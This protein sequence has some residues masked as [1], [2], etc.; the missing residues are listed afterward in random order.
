MKWLGF[1]RLFSGSTIAQRR[2]ILCRNYRHPLYMYICMTRTTTN[3]TYIER[4][5][6]TLFVN[7]ENGLGETSC[8]SHVIVIILVN[9]FR[10]PIP[11]HCALWKDLRS[12]SRFM[13]HIYIYIYIAQSI[14]WGGRRAGESG[15]SLDIYMYSMG[16]VDQKADLIRFTLIR[17]KKLNAWF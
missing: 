10:S 15:F 6:E 8:R 2:E 9:G 1:S 14:A 16:L 4:G 3:L 7:W 11:S 17:K 12:K 5:W 13:L